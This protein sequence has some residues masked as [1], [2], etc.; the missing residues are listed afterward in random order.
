MTFQSK[1]TYQISIGVTIFPNIPKRITPHHIMAKGDGILHV[2]LI[3][4]PKLSS[5]L[6]IML[7]KNAPNQ[8]FKRVSS[9]YMLY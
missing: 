3:E 6:N 8:Q 1:K 9:S 7:S 4:D 5:C 2:L